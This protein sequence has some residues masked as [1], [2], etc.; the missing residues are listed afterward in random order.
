VARSAA[1]GVLSTSLSET[2]YVGHTY[3]TEGEEMCLQLTELDREIGDFLAL[4]DS[5]G[6]DY[7]GVLTAD[8]GGK[9]IP[10]RERLAG[11]ADAAR[12]DAALSADVMGPKLSTQLGIRG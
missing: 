6:L 12:A 1:P 3:G 10:E 11:V 9:D 4:L 2:D 8:H 7:A 5:R